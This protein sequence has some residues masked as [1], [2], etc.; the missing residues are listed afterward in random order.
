MTVLLYA[1][2]VATVIER[3][4]IG[5]Q[6]MKAII[7]ADIICYEFGNMKD[8]DDDT[9]LPWE[10]VRKFVDERIDNIFE[11]AGATSAVYY[12][13][14]SKSNFRNQVA[15]I[16]PYKGH[17]P[18]EKPPYW[19]NIRQHLIDN[20]DAEVIYGME[21]DDKC[22]IEQ[23][24]DW[25]EMVKYMDGSE[26]SKGTLAEGKWGDHCNTIICSRDK[27]LKMIPGWHYSW[28]CGNQKEK[29]WFVSEQD[30]IRFFYKQLLTGDA[31]DNILGLYRVGDKAACVKQL[32]DIDDE[33]DMYCH[34][35]KE[36]KS[37]FGSYGFQF[38]EENAKLLW[39]LREEENEFP[40]LQICNRMWDFKREVRC[41]EVS[42]ESSDETSVSDEDREGQD[43]V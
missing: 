3:N 22:G 24:K 11:G 1:G 27:D 5:K 8:L 34:V 12:L 6:K 15:T 17:R 29:K 39:I 38:L 37:R 31:T 2:T 21:A 43:K 14:D 18:T 4:L 33:Y 30:G 7:D 41:E 10:I 42:Q 32:D 9:L 13:T 25:T 23:H 36:Y 19:G 40:R 35:Y 20:Y 16:L 28:E 26:W